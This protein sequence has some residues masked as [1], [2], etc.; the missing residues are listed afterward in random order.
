MLF[1]H[2]YL[3]NPRKMFERLN[4]RTLLERPICSN[5]L[6]KAYMSRVMIMLIIELR[7]PII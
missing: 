5:T 2:K 1:K 7:S 6:K 4:V 3:P